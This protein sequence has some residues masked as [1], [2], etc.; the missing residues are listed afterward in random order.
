MG[1]EQRYAASRIDSN[2][3]CVVGL[4]KW[5]RS[6]ITIR[7][8]S[9]WQIACRANA[10]PRD[11]SSFSREQRRQ[12]E[13]EAIRKMKGY[14][15]PLLLCCFLWWLLCECNC[16]QFICRMFPRLI[17]IKYRLSNRAHRGEKVAC[18]DCGWTWIRCQ[19]VSTLERGVLSR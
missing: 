5:R 10:A 9:K 3:V 8:R 4:R 19:G 13:E 11:A 15:L 2:S 17:L 7:S 18:G 14:D 1:R 12:V 6:R 16:S